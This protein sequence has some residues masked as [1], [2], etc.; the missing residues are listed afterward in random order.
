MKNPFRQRLFRKQFDNLV[1]CYDGFH[2]DL[3][4]ADGSRCRGNSIAT[5][6][7][8]GFDNIAAGM[9]APNWD[10]ASKDSFAYVAFRAGQEIA[11]RDQQVAA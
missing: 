2:R 9:R 5:H 3:R 4:R 10:R 6:F 8:R 7:W 1:A 11:K